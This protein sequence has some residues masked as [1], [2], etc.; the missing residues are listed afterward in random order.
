MGGE[1]KH[2]STAWV[3]GPAHVLVIVWHGTEAFN[4]KAFTLVPCCCLIQP[5]RVS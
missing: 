1:H 4:G 3:D 5:A 2:V